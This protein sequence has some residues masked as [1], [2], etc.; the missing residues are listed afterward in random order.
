MNDNRKWDM[1]GGCM[2]PLNF[3]TPLFVVG[4]SQAFQIW[5]TDWSW[6]VSQHI[7][8]YAREGHHLCHLTRFLEQVEQGSS[9]FAI[10]CGAIVS[11]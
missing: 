9:H 10:L 4:W 7:I 11:S 6:H 1:V 3:L 2:T 5:Y 8:N